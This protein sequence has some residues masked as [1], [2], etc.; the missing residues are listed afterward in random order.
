MFKKIATFLIL[1]LILTSCKAPQ[2]VMGKVISKSSAIW[3]CTIGIRESDNWIRS[4]SVNKA[5]CGV[6]SIGDY[7]KI[8]TPRL[9]DI[10]RP[11]YTSDGVSV[12]RRSAGIK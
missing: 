1:G 5:D 4:Y 6:I 3:P 12:K 8:E 2:P 7:I 9:Y 10:N 11:D